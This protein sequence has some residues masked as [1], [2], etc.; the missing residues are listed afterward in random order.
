MAIETLVLLATIGL[1]VSSALAAPVKVVGEIRT[2][3]AILRKYMP[4]GASAVLLCVSRSLTGPSSEW[5]PRNE[6][7]LGAFT[8]GF[9]NPEIKFEVNLPISPQ[10]KSVDLDNNGKQDAG[11]MVFKMVGG[12][13]L[14][15]DDYLEQLEQENGI[16][17]I[18]FDPKAQT[19]R[20]GTLLIYAPDAKQKISSGFGR[21]K[22][23]FTDDDP[24]VSLPAGYTLMR[25]SKEGNIDFDQSEVLKLEIYPQEE[26]KNPDFSDQTILQSFNSLVDLLKERYAYT[27]LRKIDWEKKRAQYLERV[28]EADRNKDLAEYYI[29]LY[30]FAARIRDGH[31]QVSSTDPAVF[32]KRLELVKKELDGDLGFFMIRY[33][34]GRF[35]VYSVSDDSTAKKAGI[36]IGS[37]IVRIN[38]MDVMSH[39]DSRPPMGF[40]GTEQRATQVALVFGSRFPLGTSVTVEYKRPGESEVRYANL[41][42]TKISE[43]K[44]LP[45]MPPLANRQT[46]FEMREFGEDGKYGYVRW[47]HFSN[48]PYFMSGYEAFL[49]MSYGK[50]GII[51]DM[52][53]NT[54]GLMGLFY[55]MASYMFTP[56][57]PADMGWLDF[58]AYDDVTRRF[59]KSPGEGSKKISAPIPVLAFKG[60][61]VILV[62]GGSASSGEFFP[63]FLQ[64]SGR[65]TVISDAYTDGAGGSLRLALLPGKMSFTYTGGQAFYAGTKEANLEGKGVMPDIR[66][67]IN[68]DYIRRRWNGEDVVLDTAIA[69]LKTKTAGK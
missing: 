5:V 50:P 31:V 35:M 37:E 58:Y 69:Y 21:D 68:D 20:S 47:P 15:G 54:G 13:R 8:N 55:T 60:E 40:F 6:Q 27:E 41:E 17:S 59:E 12:I 3:P 7:I 10:C 51:I 19:I 36:S 33:T 9:D 43:L 29:L 45:S 46:P 2:P 48:I 23:L 44:D 16:G 34:D 64:K 67:P 14:F 62:D 4:Q 25:I 42:A 28:K 66:V 49:S 56:E 53:G 30:D 11:I 63:Q 26:S 39:L 22:R 38:G 52:R 57:K 65:A 24:T 61:V 32:R 18:T 1:T